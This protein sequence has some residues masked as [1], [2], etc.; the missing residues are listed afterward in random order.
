MQDVSLM[1]IFA[2]TPSTVSRYIN[3]S[4]EILLEIL[5]RLKDAQVRWPKGDEFMELNALALVRH[6]LLHGAFGTL[7]GLNLPVQESADD[8]IENATYN[9]WLHSHFVSSVLAF[10]A[11]GSFLFLFLFVEG[12]RRSQV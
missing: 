6:P 3:F 1:E 9:G 12:S 2:L 11:S 7:D 10:S 4:L 8:E 5:R